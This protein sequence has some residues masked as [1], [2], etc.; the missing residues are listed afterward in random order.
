[1]GYGVQ[2]TAQL[3]A[4]LGSRVVVNADGEAVAVTGGRAAG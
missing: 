2:L 4:P 3:A 1:V